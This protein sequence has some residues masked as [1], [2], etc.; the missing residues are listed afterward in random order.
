MDSRRGL[1]TVFR[2]AAHDACPRGRFILDSDGATMRFLGA[3]TDLQWDDDDLKSFIISVT[4]GII[5]ATII[6]LLIRRRG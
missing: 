6:A 5:T 2:Y 4:A 3:D 1:G